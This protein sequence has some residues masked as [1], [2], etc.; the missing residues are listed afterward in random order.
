M[1][2]PS[3]QYMVPESEEELL[4]FL[5]NNKGETRLAAGGTDLLPSM[6]Q[7]LYRPRS[8]VLLNRLPRL[9]QIKFNELSGLTIGPLVTLND[10]E[11]STLVKEKY[12]V[13]AQ[14]AGLV[15][16]PQLRYMGTVGGNLNLD[17]RCFYFNQSSSWRKCR[18]VCVKAGG[19]TCN[20]IGGGKKC[21]AAFS[22]D[23]AP[24]LVSLGATVRLLSGEGE[25]TVPLAEYYTGDGANPFVRRD[26][27]LLA[28]IEVPVLP[29]SVFCSYHKYSIRKAIDFPLAGV[30]VKVELDR[31]RICKDIK[32]VLGAVSP[33]PREVEAAAEVLKGK[34]LKTELLEQAAEQAFK[35]AKPVANLGSTPSYRKIMVRE[36]VRKAL[37]RIQSVSV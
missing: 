5:K 33:K 15:G 24:V 6:K 23:L 3:F 2:L 19:E 10:L 30:A 26:D 32:I 8:L 34:E 37:F 25:R 31:D 4:G 12:P 14:A 35:A 29:E 20:A 13:V 21:F 27:E 36:F 22:G 16:S 1:R 9:G 7:G 17:T 28:G 11:T 18:P